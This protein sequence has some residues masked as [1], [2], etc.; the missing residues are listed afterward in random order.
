MVVFLLGIVDGQA[1]SSKHSFLWVSV[2]QDVPGSSRILPSWCFQVKQTSTGEDVGSSLHTNCTMAQEEGME[3][4]LHRDI[5]KNMT[6]GS[7]H[8]ECHRRVTRDC[9]C[10][11]SPRVKRHLYNQV[12]KSWAVVLGARAKAC[13]AIQWAE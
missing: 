6:E 13:R 8:R 2:C 5:R 4:S 9:S 12:A 7:P 1:I 11:H 3:I 10:Q